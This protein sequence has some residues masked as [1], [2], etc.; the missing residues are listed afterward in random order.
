MD[1]LAAI[2]AQTEA[3]ERVKVSVPEWGCD[4]W[5]LSELTL[6]EKANV[7][8]GAPANDEHAL[9]INYLILYAENEDGTPAFPDRA[10]A[11]ATLQESLVSTIMGIFEK[12]GRPESVGEAKNA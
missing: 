5:F 10:Q 7:E 4:L 2:A 11:R 3:R 12:I 1:I 9:M 6:R 8:A